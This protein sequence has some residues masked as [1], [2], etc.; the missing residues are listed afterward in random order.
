MAQSNSLAPP[1]QRQGARVALS[2]TDGPSKRPLFAQESKRRAPKKPA[3][4]ATWAP[5]SGH[6]GEALVSQ[7]VDKTFSTLCGSRRRGLMESVTFSHPGERGSPQEK[8]GNAFG[9]FQALTPQQGGQICADQ[10]GFMEGVFQKD[11]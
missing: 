4:K 1:E 7:S 3:T 5:Q 10:T 2:A 8:K 9:H 6:C 11:F